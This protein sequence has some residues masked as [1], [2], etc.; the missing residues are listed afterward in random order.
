MHSEQNDVFCRSPVMEAE[1]IPAAH[2][3]SGT[4]VSYT[5]VQSTSLKT[6]NV[7]G[8]VSFSAEW[9]PER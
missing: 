3:K 9:L 4:G 6:K 8:G 1:F 2:L 5:Y 7:S